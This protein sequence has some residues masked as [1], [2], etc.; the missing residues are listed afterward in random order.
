MTELPRHLLPPHARSRGVTAILGPTNTG[1]THHAIER[2]LSHQSGI[3]GLPLRLLAREV[4]QKLIERVGPGAV[5]LITGEEKI[6]PVGARYY[7]C[8]VEAMPQ[9]IEAD[10]VAVDEVQLAGDFERGHVFTDRLLHHRG[11]YETLL[12]GAAT[13]RPLIAALL[14][15]A[16]ITARPRL[17]TLT[18]AGAKKLTRLPARSAVVA[19]SASEVYQIAELIRRQRGGAAVVLG[20]L[21]PRTRNA[22][23]ELFQSGAVDFL[24]ATDA[25]GMGLNLDVDHIAFAGTRKF[26]GYQ[27]RNLNPAELAQVAGRAGRFMRDGTFGTS[28][29]ADELDPEIVKRIEGH[30]F[31]PLRLLQWR[32]P[33]LEFS[34]LDALRR[35]LSLSPREVGLTRAPDGE[36]VVTLEAAWRDSSLKDMARSEERVRLLW[37]SCQVPDYRKVSPAAHA[38]LCHDI[39][40]FIAESGR[41]P[42]DWLAKQVAR[43]DA[44]DGDIDTLSMRIA[45]IRTWSFIANQANWLDD[46]R[47]WR[48]TTARLEDRL[49]DALHD[50]LAHRFVD[51]TTSV[52]MRRLKENMMLEA[53]VNQAGEVTIADQVVGRLQ[54]F[55]FVPESGAEVQYGKELRAAAAKALEGAIAGRA[56]RVA[57]AGNESFLLASNG[58]IRWQGEEIARLIAGDTELEPR[59]K[60]LADD[61][62]SG[63]HREWV[64]ARVDA[65]VRHHIGALL[66]PLI[67]LRTGEGLEGLARGIAFRLVE[68]LGVI[69]RAKV[70][71]DVKSLDQ[72]A[73]SALRRLG[74]R[75][76]A[77]H[78]FVPAT[79]KPKP[80]ELAA[81]LW[82]L[83][84]GGMSP[85]AMLELP[86]LAQS[87]RTSIPVNAEVPKALYRVLGYRILG[88]RAVRVDILERL[89]DIIRPL[90]AYR[91]GLTAGAPPKGAAGGDGF[92]VTVEMTSLAG[93]SGE[94]FASIL[95]GLGYRS[96]TKPLA[97][98][99]QL[100]AEATAKAEAEAAAQAKIAAERAAEEAARQA[101][102]QA[103]QAAAAASAEAEIPAVNEAAS[104]ALADRPAEASVVESA[105]AMIEATVSPSDIAEEPVPVAEVEMVSPQQETVEPMA[106]EPAPVERLVTEAVAVESAALPASSPDASALVEGTEPVG[107]EAGEAAQAPAETATAETV[108]AETAIAETVPAETAAVEGEAAPAAPAEPATIMIWHPARFER[109]PHGNNNRQGRKPPHQRGEA[110]QAAPAEGAAAP[111]P[112]DGQPQHGHGRN[113]RQGQRFGQNAEQRPDRRPPRRDRQERDGER[114]PRPPQGAQ[115]DRRPDTRGEGGQQRAERPPRPRDQDRGQ[116][117]DKRSGRD[118]RNEAPRIYSSQPSAGKGGPDPD[119]PFAKLAL[120]KERMEA[121]KKS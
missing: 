72:A 15:G 24:V 28:G 120:L 23:V 81:Q 63:S 61:D 86:L 99:E 64:Q 73:R 101:A 108:L 90:I 52:L 30:D 96:E 44:V 83:R 76:G 62:L 97:E 87:G 105:G 106:T 79:M 35:T 103:E 55:R 21:S 53:N 1:K 50:R 98:H 27:F 11:R 100:M 74:V 119:S 19:F 12:L 110:A 85:E 37:Q 4:Y 10:F 36:D 45:H 71:D 17:S 18:Y 91:P 66:K 54:G 38:E 57:E 118:Q 109:R 92:V 75:F 88:Q 16:L 102:A 104:E 89:A 77:Y 39:F 8:T 84:H 34:S 56:E 111:R 112:E 46:P 13:I 82:A 31:E 22:Q 67:D 3:I 41:L 93:C 51:K 69:E 33:G 25:I 68:D 117:P 107:G 78:L 2:M 49:S 48:E 59:A 42:E 9:D 43:C 114:P 6:K 70:A 40:R 26:D 5:A 115:G 116:R 58:S 20:A 95:R 121:D 47:Y 29:R 80:R 60:L 7:V 113:E 32:N 65:W 14:P 94:D